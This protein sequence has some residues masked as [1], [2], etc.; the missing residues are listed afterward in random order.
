[1]Y[2]TILYPMLRLR[3]FRELRGLSLRKL[4]RA[5]GVHYVSVVRLESGD[6]D[7]RL[8]TVR[9]LAKALHVSIAELVGEGKHHKK[10]G[11]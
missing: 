1:M 8:S 11:R 3:E 2:A 10:G 9:K 7:P 6:F 5:A 4:A